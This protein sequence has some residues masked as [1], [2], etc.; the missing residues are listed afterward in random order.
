MGIFNCTLYN[1]LIVQNLV[2]NPHKGQMK[3]ALVSG[4]LGS[5]RGQNEKKSLGENSKIS[6]LCVVKKTSTIEILYTYVKHLLRSFSEKQDI[7][8]DV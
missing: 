4:G 8:C 6:S 5:D 7:L 2:E 3:R 1:K